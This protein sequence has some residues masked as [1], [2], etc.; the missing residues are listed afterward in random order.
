MI[1]CFFPIWRSLLDWR[2]INFLLGFCVMVGL[3]VIGNLIF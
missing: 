3:P 2:A 1:F